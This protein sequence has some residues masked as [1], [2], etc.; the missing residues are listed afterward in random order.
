MFRIFIAALAWITLAWFPAQAVPSQQE[1]EQEPQEERLV[2]Y[3]MAY[4]VSCAVREK[5]TAFLRDNFN[6]RVIIG[7]QAQGPRMPVM[8]PVRSFLEVWVSDTGSWTVVRV[9]GK[10]ACILTHG[11]NWTQIETID[12]EAAPPNSLQH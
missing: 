1:E 10:V 12:P 8:G 7:A 9:Y 4:P 2:T 11:E 6:E 5:L 3:R